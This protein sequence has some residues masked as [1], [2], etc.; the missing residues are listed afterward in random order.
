[1]IVEDT[2]EWL[3]EIGHSRLKLAS[4]AAGEMAAATAMPIAEFAEWLKSSIAAQAQPVR[5]WLCAV[6]E[7]RVIQ[8]VLSALDNAGIENRRVRTDSVELAVRPAYSGLG[9][10][11]WLALQ[12]MWQE[13]RSA[14]MLAD[15]GTA[16]TID[17]VN[18][19]G[20]HQGGWI[21][22]GR[23]A[24]R[25]GLIESAPGLKRQTFEVRSEH[26]VQPA[27]AT[28][29]A[30]ERGLLLQQAGA[31]A[32]AL[33]SLQHDA[34]RPM[35]IVLIGGDAERIRPAIESARSIYTQCKQTS[36][37]A[38]RSTLESSMASIRVAPDLVL[39]GLAMAAEKLR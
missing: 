18:A 23:D 27:K 35:R 33:Q 7:D 37:A 11:R 34:D 16:T 17:M 9:V 21:L 32:L 15:C 10:D 30:V 8:P 39:Q 13:V 3:I 26:F 2:F 5:V 38:S 6:P 29:E 24:S 28:V 14:F 31:I 12:P 22:P 19:N 4:Y 1:M 20:V 36:S 25:A